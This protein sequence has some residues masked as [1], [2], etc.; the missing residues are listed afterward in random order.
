[1]FFIPQNQLFIKIYK[2]P[3][4]NLELWIMLFFFA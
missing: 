4:N 1:M 2:K 3:K